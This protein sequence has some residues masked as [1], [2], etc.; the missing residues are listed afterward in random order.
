MFEFLEDSCESE[1]RGQLEKKETPDVPGSSKKRKHEASR[2]KLTVPD[3]LEYNI[4]FA[5]NAFLD[6]LCKKVPYNTFFDHLE[7]VYK[8]GEELEMDSKDNGKMLFQI[9]NY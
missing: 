5:V 6:D 7:L 2:T 9:L 8:L 1:S 3:T 4:L